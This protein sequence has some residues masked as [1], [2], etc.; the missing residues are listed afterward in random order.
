[1]ISS[2]I[3][4]KCNNIQ[5]YSIQLYSRDGYINLKSHIDVILSMSYYNVISDNVIQFNNNTVQ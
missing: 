4:Y 1:M 3:A 5:L 2:F